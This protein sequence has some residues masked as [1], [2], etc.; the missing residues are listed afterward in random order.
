MCLGGGGGGFS[1]KTAVIMCVGHIMMVAVSL[2]HA[3]LRKCHML[4]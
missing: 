3:L 2:C 4:Q 1:S